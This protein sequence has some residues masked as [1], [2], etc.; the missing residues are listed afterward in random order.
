MF[1][2]SHPFSENSGDL[3]AFPF[4]GKHQG[5]VHE[6]KKWDFLLKPVQQQFLKIG[7]SFVRDPKYRFVRTGVAMNGLHNFDIQLIGRPVDSIIKRA[8]FEPALEIGKSILHPGPYFIIRMHIFFHQQ[9][10][11][12]LTDR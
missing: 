8:D 5:V 2:F 7:P 3:F 1:G 10:E 12:T 11:N 9:A 6:M 4:P